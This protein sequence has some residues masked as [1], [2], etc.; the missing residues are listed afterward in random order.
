MVSARHL[1]RVVF[2]LWQ[3]PSAGHGRG[4][5]EERRREFVVAALQMVIE[6]ERGHGPR[7]TRANP[8]QHRKPCPRQLGRPFEIDQTESFGKFHVVFDGVGK[9]LGSSNGFKNDVARFIFAH[10]DIGAGKIG[11]SQQQRIEFFL[12]RLHIR[13][14]FLDGDRQ[15]LHLFALRIDFVFGRL[16]HSSVERVARRLVLLKRGNFLAA[17]RR[18]FQHPVNA[19]NLASARQQLSGLVG[20]FFEQPHVQHERPPCAPAH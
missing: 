1:K 8:G 10:G 16:L 12:E 19:G 18:Q 4:A 7:K 5:N 20:I 2:K 3:L 14:C 17:G 13:F 15:R 9:A 6:H 11:N